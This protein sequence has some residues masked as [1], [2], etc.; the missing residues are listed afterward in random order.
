MEIDFKRKV[1][2]YVI[3]SVDCLQYKDVEDLKITRTTELYTLIMN[4]MS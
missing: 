1:P 2:I 3:K 4:L